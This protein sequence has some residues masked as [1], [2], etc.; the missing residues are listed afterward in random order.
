MYKSILNYLNHKFRLALENPLHEEQFRAELL[1]DTY[2]QNKIA[3]IIS[4]CVYILY[5]PLTYFMVPEDLHIVTLYNFFLP[6]LASI[7]FLIFYKN[8]TTHKEFLLLIYG[9]IMGITPII[10]IYYTDPSNYKIYFL[11]L[12]LPILGLYVGV[13]ISFVIAFLSTTFLL[14]FFIF[15]ILVVGVD[16]IESLH[17][18]LLIVDTYLLSAIGG[19]T[20]ERSKRI[21][22]LRKFKEHELITQTITDPL[23]NQYN[24]RFLDEYFHYYFEIATEKRKEIVCMMLDIDFF[25]L[26]NDTYGHQNGDI[27][28][29]K[30]AHT[31]K[32]HFNNPNEFVNRYGG[33]EFCI[34]LLDNQKES[35]AERAN[36]LIKAIES[37]KI[38]HEKS[39]VSEF[40]TV[41]IGLFGEISDETTT[42]NSL[43]QEADKQ[44]YEAK[45]KGRNTLFCN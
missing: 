43:I 45:A 44:L 24:R 7:L 36:G 12:V 10:L 25:K 35:V 38:L 23:T 8:I 30:V 3:I 17:S 29:K 27:V 19:Y 20:A 40:V 26:Y 39:T 34:M 11:N 16:L 14:L 2:T 31:I 15:T 4:M 41:S 5:T 22:F 9:I 32:E 6:L 1:A 33:E 21:Q 13:G 18:L 42:I 37:L 28:L